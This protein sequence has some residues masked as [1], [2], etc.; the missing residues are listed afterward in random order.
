[1]VIVIHRAIFYTP[2]KTTGL[3]NAVR[4]CFHF[5][6][7]T[8]YVQAGEMPYKLVRDDAKTFH[9]LN[10]PVSAHESAKLTCLLAE[11]T[12]SY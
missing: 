2:A 10:H 6:Q 11:D 5:H 9:L 7:F 8:F 12:L 3:F 1:M 4:S